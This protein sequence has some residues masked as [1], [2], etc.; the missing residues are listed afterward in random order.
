MNDHDPVQDNA[1]ER[2]EEAKDALLSRRQALVRGGATRGR[3]VG[4][5]GR[6]ERRHMLPGLRQHLHRDLHRN[7]LRYLRGRM[8]DYMHVP[9]FRRVPLGV[10][11]V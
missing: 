6:H 10:L 3:I 7:L 9:G 5:V 2:L 8:L 11:R 1:D 4:S